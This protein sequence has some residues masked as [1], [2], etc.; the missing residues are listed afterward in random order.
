[1]LNLSRSAKWLLALSPVKTVGCT[2]GGAVRQPTANQGTAQ[3]AQP[4][5]QQLHVPGS[6]HPTPII[7]PTH[8]LTQA[9][10]GAVQPSTAPPSVQ[11]TAQFTLSRPQHPHVPG[12][13]HSASTT[14]PPRLLTQARPGLAL[15]CTVQDRTVQD[16]AQHTQVRPHQTLGPGP[17]HSAT[18]TTIPHMLTETRPSTA[19]PSAA[20]RSTVQPNTVQDT[21]QHVDNRP[22]PSFGSGMH[23]PATMAMGVRFSTQGR[24]SA[25]QPNA[26]QPNTVQP[27]TMQGSLAPTLVAQ[28]L[29]N[30]PRPTNNMAPA[31]PASHPPTISHR[32]VPVTSAPVA[33]HPT[34][35]RPP[36]Q[37]LAPVNVA[38]VQQAHASR[39]AASTV[40]AM[41]QQ[42]SGAAAINHMSMGQPAGREMAPQATSAVHASAPVSRP[43]MFTEQGNALSG[44]LLP[45]SHLLSCHTSIAK[46]YA[47]KLRHVS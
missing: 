32:P 26:A 29:T 33:M 46:L 2:A 34:Q 30:T 35:P 15:P 28:S 41:M 16:T 11:D 4:R 3:L 20:Q 18:N 38:A 14:M 27:V 39:P 40:Q 22:Q 7:N 9:R 36:L 43:A 47:N 44:P 23:H 10:P 25:A 21:T 5:P 1:M 8:M 19:Q 6:Q 12:P 31:W 42:P 17:H 45:C 37:S 13:Q 24:P